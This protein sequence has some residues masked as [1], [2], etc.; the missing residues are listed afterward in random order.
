MLRTS[1][2]FIVG[3]CWAPRLD[4]MASEAEGS[5]TEIEPGLYVALSK[6]PD[7]GLG[8]FASHDFAVG[9][10][11]AKYTG[12]LLKTTEA[13][14]LADKSY[15][16]RLGPQKYVDCRE[17]M[18]VGARYINDCRRKDM[19]NVRFEKRPD[20]NDALVIAIKAIAAGDEIYVDYGRWYWASTKGNTLPDRK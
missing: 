8:L 10:L 18:D 4:T 1:I 3:F 12:K 9:A 20:E 19:Y 17:C 2:Q 7:A 13:L 16:M 11:V 5:Q 6:I 15:L 14:R